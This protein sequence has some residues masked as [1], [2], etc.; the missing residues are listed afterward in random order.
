MGSSNLNF[1]NFGTHVPP[2]AIAAGGG[3]R[4]G[5]SSLPRQP[6]IYSLTFG[7]FHNKVGSFGKD[8]GSI[9][10]DELLRTLWN[11]EEN[12]NV[13]STSNHYD[14]GRNHGSGYLQR[15]GSLTVPRM[16]S[17]KTVDEVWRDVVKEYGG[18]KDTWSGTT[19]GFGALHHR[20][21]TLD[22]VTLEEFLVRAGVVKEETQLG[23]EAKNVD[24]FGNLLHPVNNFGGGRYNSNS[25]LDV[26]GAQSVEQ[27]QQQTAHLHQQQQLILPKQPTLEYGCAA[28][29]LDHVI[30]QNVPIQGLGGNDGGGVSVVTGSSGVSSD[31]VARCNGDTSSVSPVPYVFNGG[32]RGRK[33]GALEKVVERRQRR[34]IKNR[35]SAARSRDRKQVYTMELES[36]V[37][38]LKEE[39]EL[40]QKKQAEMLE[41]Q[42]NQEILEEMQHN[43]GNKRRCLRRTQTGPW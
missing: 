27:Q 20:Q 10:I 14:G 38:K 8:F 41:M 4:L 3:R 1:D 26:N 34:M 25:P 42:K 2:E 33:S 24:L 29:G 11:A 32:S 12:Q 28:V 9:N 37:A 7:E 35:E 43:N 22:E 39:N 36:K 5:N 18:E 6:S 40:L 17:Q 13:G 21:P 31:G 15:Q 16:F 23:Q 19:G 30:V